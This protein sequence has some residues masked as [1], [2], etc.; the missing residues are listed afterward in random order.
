MKT[1]RQKIKLDDIILVDEDMSFEQYPFK[2]LTGSIKKNGWN[3]AFPSLSYHGD[4][5]T[6][7][8]P[9]AAFKQPNNKYRIPNGKHR[10]LALKEL[11]IN[12]FD[13]F[14]VDFDPEYSKSEKEIQKIVDNEIKE[15]DNNGKGMFQSFSF[16]Y[17]IKMKRRDASDKIFNSTDWPFL[18]YTEKSVLDVAC[19]GGAFAIL[20]KRYGAEKVVGFD[21]DDY[22]IK[23]AKLY[24]SLYDIDDID[25]QVKDFWDFDW[26][27]MQYDIVIG[28]QFI[29]HVANDKEGYRGAR[30]SKYIDEA[31]DLM[32]NAKK[33]T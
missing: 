16:P 11:G 9:F 2:L 24:A 26:T 21:C 22:V 20:A 25:L 10:Y 12:E 6:Y 15:L 27:K 19:N 29:Y 14:V 13:A 32:C 5:S 8:Q 7:E 30:P 1:T 28:S 4:N 23:K 17:G 3:P 18:Y 33:I 31:L